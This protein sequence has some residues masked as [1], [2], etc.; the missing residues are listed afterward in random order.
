MKWTYLQP[1]LLSL[2]KLLD[3]CPNLENKLVLRVVPTGYIP[4]AVLFNVRPTFAYILRDVEHAGLQVVEGAL[5]LP[6]TLFK[7]RARGQYIV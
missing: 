2:D 4:L 3:E 7:W 1:L 6:L 5:L